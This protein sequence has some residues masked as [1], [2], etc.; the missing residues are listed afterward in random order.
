[1]IISK[2]VPMQISRK[3]FSNFELNHTPTDMVFV[4][5]KYDDEN[6][7]KKI[8]VQLHY[9]HIKEDIEKWIKENGGFGGGTNRP[10][11]EIPTEVQYFPIV[12]TDEYGFEIVDEE[13]GLPMKNPDTWDENTQTNI[14]NVNEKKGFIEING[15]GDYTTDCIFISQPYTGI[16]TTIVVDNTGRIQRT[17]ETNEEWIQNRVP[18]EDFVL[19]YGIKTEDYETVLVV[20]PYHRGIVQIL[21]TKKNDLVINSSYTDAMT[22]Y[23]ADVMP[24]TDNIDNVP[25]EG[26][27]TKEVIEGEEKKV[28][29][30]MNNEYG[31]IEIDVAKDGKGEYTFVFDDTELGSMTY[32]VIDNQIN[33]QKNVMINYGKVMPENDADIEYNICEVEMG[34]KAIIQVFHSLSVDVVANITKI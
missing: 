21:H 7:E 12:R 18:T 28:Y 33:P 19:N 4:G 30:D 24:T 13:T 29:V 6:P 20:P 8:N 22:Q 11:S 2:C 27:I 5:W 31:F 1:M 23:I 32:I 14:I 17:N 10:I 26:E 25:F 16:I 15:G 34:E 9:K 3:R